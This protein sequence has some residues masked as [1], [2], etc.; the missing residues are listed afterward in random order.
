LKKE[1]NIYV[2]DHIHASGLELLHR[3]GLK[4]ITKYG[5]T[6]DKLIDFIARKDNKT[7]FP[8]ALI[9]R[10]VRKIQSSDLEKIKKKTKIEYLCTASSG[11]DNVDYLYAKKLGFKVLNVPDGN[12]ISAAEHTLA[13]ILAISKNIYNS[14]NRISK[15][16]FS[17]SAYVNIELYHK[18]I[19]II[20]IGRVGSYLAKLCRAFEMTILGNDIK[21]NL[22]NKYKWIHFCRLKYLVKHSDIISVHT[23]FDKS[24]EN[25]ISRKLMRDFKKDSI[26]INCARGGIVDENVLIFLLKTGKLFYA[27]IDVF[28]NE[29]NINSDFK[30]LRNVILTPHQAGKTEE[31]KIRISLKLAE[32]LIHLCSK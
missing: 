25:L 23:P 28:K 15:T 2:A 11:F 8:S 16:A 4:V 7:V 24:T 3:K 9:I 5:L 29:P 12:Y 21:K 6:N 19:G 10:S 18:T 26:L 1:L 20:G 14:S 27:G 30:K 22:V 31:S 32:S 13:L 17:S